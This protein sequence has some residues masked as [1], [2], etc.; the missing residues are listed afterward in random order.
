[1]GAGKEGLSG[2]LDGFYGN[3]AFGLTNISRG[4]S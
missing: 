3:V 1:M 2:N 4:E